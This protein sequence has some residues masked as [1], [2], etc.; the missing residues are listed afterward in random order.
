ME[1]CFDG[2]AESVFAAEEAG[3][4]GELR[5]AR[6][7]GAV[8][9]AACGGGFKD[10]ESETEALECAANIVKGCPSM[11]KGRGDRPGG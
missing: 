7:A 1:D 8:I 3:F 6:F 11:I 9:G 2:A 4:I 10:I 5:G